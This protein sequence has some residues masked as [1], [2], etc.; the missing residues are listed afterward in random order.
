LSAPKKKTAVKKPAAERPRRISK[1][2]TAMGWIEDA[3]GNVLMVKQK[4]GKKLW[5]LPGGKV[6]GHERVDLGLRREIKEETGL[7]VMQAT[8][9]TV[10]D[11]PD[12]SNLTF[13]Y[14]VRV[15][16]GGNMKPQPT[17]IAEIQSRAALPR[18]ATPS[19]RYFW[20]LMRSSSAE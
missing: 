19:L 11:R 13:L 20:K 7:D 15:K 6:E 16:A 14:R 3:F 5:A 1:E 9:I 10:F 18:Q 2:V 4:R 17:E 8:F 12:K